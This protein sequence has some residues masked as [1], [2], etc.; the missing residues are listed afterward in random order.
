VT[1]ALHAQTHLLPEAE[2]QRTLEAVRCSAWFGAMS[3]DGTGGAPVRRRLWHAAH[4]TEMGTI[5][6]DHRVCSVAAPSPA[7]FLLTFQGFCDRGGLTRH[8]ETAS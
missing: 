8:E 4:A 3:S 6:C 5:V 1:V 7:T 2:A